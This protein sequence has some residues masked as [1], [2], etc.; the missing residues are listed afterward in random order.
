MAH[1]Q[2]F[3]AGGV[4]VC[5]LQTGDDLAAAVAKAAVLIEIGIEASADE[6]AVALVHGKLV[7]ERRAER[8][9]HRGR[10]PA[11]PDDDAVELLRQPEGVGG[12]GEMGGKVLRGADGIAHG[13][14]IAGAASP[15]RKP[16]QRAGEI[17]RAFQRLAQGVAEARLAGEIADG[18][19]P[20]VDG[21]GI[22]ERTAEPRRKL[23]R[24]GA[25]D[26]A[27]DGGEQAADAGALVG[28]DQ[29]EIGA[30]GGVDQEQAPGNLLAR[31]PHQRRPPDLGDVDIG[32]E[33]GECCELGLGEVAEAVQRADM[34][35]RLQRPLAARGIV[36]RAWDR[37][38]RGASAFDC[39]AQRRLAGMVVAD[40]DFAWAEA[41]QLA[42]EVALG[43]RR[44]QQLAGGD[45][46]GGERVSCLAALAHGPAEQRG[47][48]IVGAGIE[49]ALLG[50]GA[51]GDKADHV[52][53]DHG[54]RPALPR[55][56]RILDLLAN[57]NAVALGDQALEVVVGGVDRHAAHRDVLAQMLAALGERDAE[58]ARGDGRVVEEQLVE[59]PHAVEQEA[60]GIG[61]FDLEILGHHRGGRR[62]PGVFGARGRRV[63]PA[64]AFG[65][66]PSLRPGHDQGGTHSVPTIQGRAVCRGNRPQGGRN[67]GASRLPLI[68]TGASS[69]VPPL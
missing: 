56:R 12:A 13:A 41:H 68:V 47:E 28:A 31:R 23:A 60:I 40:E 39:G 7:G 6:A 38:Q 66:C 43:D 49:Q 24:A 19:E 1:L 55:F 46:E 4:G 67:R 29:L 63:G 65:V 53:A 37:R 44:R 62:R 42:S 32:E 61:G 22:G 45:V 27:V 52:A 35:A 50:Q 58:R 3:D 18:I 11:Q 69:R 9:L 36:M 17:G 10:H 59:I 25:G 33:A 51:R 20:G 15:Q 14:E 34:K 2:R 16:R 26:G 30:G 54:L 5:G 64:N 8:L 48:E 21:G 57:G